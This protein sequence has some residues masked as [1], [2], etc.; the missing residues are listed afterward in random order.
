MVGPQSFSLTPSQTLLEM[1]S[2]VS[3]TISLLL[4]ILVGYLLQKRVATKD[5]RAGI[6]EIILSVALPAMIFL[7]IQKINFQMQMILIPVLALG[8]NLLIFTL[9]DLFAPALK[10]QKD[11]PAFR[12]FKMLI[13]S[14]APGLSC[15][16][17]L[18]EYFGETTLANAALADIGNKVFVLIILYLVAM[19]WYYHVQ[20]VEA[21]NN[22]DKIKDLL[23]AMIKEPVNFAIFLGLALLLL[24]INYQSFPSFLQMS[25]DRL[26]VIMTPLILLFIG[27]SVKFKWSQIK[28][29]TSMLLLKSALAFAFSGAVI[30]TFGVTDP[31]MIMLVILFPQSSFSFWPYAHMS[32]IAS[33]EANRQST[34]QRTFD[35]D[36]AMNMLAMSLPFSTIMILGLSTF[37][38][39]VSAAPAF[40]FVMA[41]IL[42]SV[43]L[44]K[45]FVRYMQKGIIF[46]TKGNA[47][48]AE[49]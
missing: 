41:V 16:P 30:T 28:T 14:L 19:K 44:F 25:V 33:M 24:G 29:I 39:S 13:P 2:A 9:A 8:F 11:T 36:Y 49:S 5:N 3:K 45:P 40:P 32:A 12:T 43:V 38:K 1:N 46:K 48:I 7:S 27:I 47:E 17:F 15:F 18:L 22:T 26:S 34:S 31:A 20:K 10:I 21:G 23:S 4:L 6:K 42:L 37:S 35:L